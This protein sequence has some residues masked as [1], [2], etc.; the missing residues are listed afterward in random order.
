MFISAFCQASTVHVPCMQHI[1]QERWLRVLDHMLAL[2]ESSVQA[3]SP[4]KQ[5]V[6]E[7]AAY[8]VGACIVR[9]PVLAASDLLSTLDAL[10]K[11][12]RSLAQPQA[13]QLQSLVEQ[14]RRPR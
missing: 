3:L 10:S 14:A 5:A 4:N 1:L 6:C 7:F 13:V 2:N 12:A 11:L 9:E 8:I